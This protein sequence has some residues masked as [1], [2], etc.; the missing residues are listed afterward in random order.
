[1]ACIGKGGK[2]GGGKNS[3][4]AL[5]KNERRKIDRSK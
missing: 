2:K 1:M 3:K 5:I 4:A